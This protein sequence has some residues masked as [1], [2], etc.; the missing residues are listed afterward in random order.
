MPKFKIKHGFT[1]KKLS[2]ENSIRMVWKWKYLN[3]CWIILTVLTNCLKLWNNENNNLA[4]KN[5]H[6]WKLEN[7]LDENPNQHSCFKT[8]IFSENKISTSILYLLSILINSKVMN[9][10]LKEDKR[11]CF[12]IFYVSKKEFLNLSNVFV[13]IRVLCM[14]W[15]IN[16]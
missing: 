7:W 5:L 8:I 14:S 13:R 11:N 10:S 2:L 9:L 12:G 15:H 3:L 4:E 16:F 6:T 1:W